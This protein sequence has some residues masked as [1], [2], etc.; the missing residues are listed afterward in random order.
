MVSKYGAACLHCMALPSI[1]L[2]YVMVSGQLFFYFFFIFC[3]VCGLLDDNNNNNNNNNKY[4]T[5]TMAM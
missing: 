3:L 2:N 1:Q 5:I 4:N